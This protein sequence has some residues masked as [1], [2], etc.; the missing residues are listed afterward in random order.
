M[1]DP[2]GATEPWREGGAGREGR[3]R[4]RPNP[5]PSEVGVEALLLSLFLMGPGLGYSV[6][7]D[8]AFREKRGCGGAIILCFCVQGDPRAPRT[9]SF[10]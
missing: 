1:A 4:G 9:S 7:S 10:P 8:R 2:S 5:G 6:H 3:P